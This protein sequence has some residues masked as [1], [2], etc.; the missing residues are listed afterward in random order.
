MIVSKSTKFEKLFPGMDSSFACH[1]IP[2]EIIHDGGPPYNGSEWR[3]Y[4]AACGFKSSL[5]TPEHPQSN[6]LAEKF[7]SSL[8][9]L[10]HASISEHK[11]PKT[12][13]TKFLMTYR[14]TPHSSTGKTPASLMMDRK[15]RTKLPALIS[16]PKSEKHL[17]AQKKDREAKTKQKEYADRHRK[18]KDIR[19]R[20]IHCD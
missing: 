2:E 16:T 17:E 18:A 6:S 5:C 8:V 4:A 11:N 12:E 9:K 13:I 10:T 7:M 1:G 14:N 15:I 20:S 19:P 3:K